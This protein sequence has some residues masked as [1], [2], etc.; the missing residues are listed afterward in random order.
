MIQYIVYYECV[1]TY[2]CK[3]PADSTIRRDVLRYKMTRRI[4]P[5]AWPFASKQVAV[6]VV[7]SKGILEENMLNC[8][9]GKLSK[10]V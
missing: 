10:H 6:N 2:A 8:C 1:Q 5:L 7:F 4:A 3:D 9:K